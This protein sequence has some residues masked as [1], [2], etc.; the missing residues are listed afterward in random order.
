MK[1]FINVLLFIWELPQNLVGLVLK[2]LFSTDQLYEDVGKPLKG[3]YLWKLSGSISLGHYVLLDRRANETTLKHEQGHQKQS[4][5]L[6]WLYLLVIGLPSI[7]WAGLH[8]YTIIG[9]KKSYYWFYTEAWA[10]KLGG[11]NR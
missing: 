1:A 8:S 10:D 7:I 9:R 11:V 2:L 5:Y 3:V 4:H 6:G